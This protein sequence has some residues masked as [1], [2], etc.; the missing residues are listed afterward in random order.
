[1]HSLNGITSLFN[2]QADEKLIAEKFGSG[3][4]V[5]VSDIT[6][7]FDLAAQIGLNMG[8]ARCQQLYNRWVGLVR[9]VGIYGAFLQV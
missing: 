8:E 5:D 6:V 7:E 3:K 1:M 2:S 9:Q 4:Q